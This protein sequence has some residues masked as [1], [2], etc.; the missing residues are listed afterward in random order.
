MVLHLL[1]G[2]EPLFHV[3]AYQLVHPLEFGLYAIL[4]LAG[5]LISVC[6]VKLL[7]WI[8]KQFMRLPA[9]TQWAQPV[10]GGTVVGILGWFVPGALGVGYGYVSQALNGQMALGM[11]AL[12]VILKLI[13]TTTCYSSG[14]AG[15]IFGPSLFIGAMLGG[16]TGGAAH[17]FLPDYTG[18]VGA[19]ALVGMG[20]TFAGIVRTPLTSVIMIF[21]VTRDYSIIVPLM[22]SNLIAYFISSR[23]QAEP[24]YEALQHQDGI[25]LPAGA[26]DREEVLLV[27][28]GMHPPAEQI[29][30]SE[31]V[32][33]V[34]SRVH[35]GQG[36]WPVVD[37]DGL[38]GMLSPSRL[39]EALQQGRGNEP[40]SALL[41]SLEPRRHMKAENFPH[42]HSDHTLDSAM[43]RMAQT[44]LTTLPV[45][46]RADIRKLEAVIS[47]HDIMAA[48]GLEKGTAPDAEAARQQ[49]KPPLSAFGG[50]VAALVIAL[51]LI[52]VL[53][54]VY[55]SGRV[56]RARQ[57]YT[58]GAAEL[59][60][61]RYEEAVEHLRNALSISHGPTERLALAQALLK[62]GRLDE[63][64]LYFHELL[65]Q[66]PNSG[67]AHLGL[68]RIAVAGKDADLAVREYH[69]AIDGS[70]P[71]DA[72]QNRL[73]ARL[74]LIETLGRIGRNKQAQSELLAQF[75]A[76]PSDPAARK[77]IAGLLLRFGLPK[78]AAEVY[79][80][81]LQARPEDAEAQAGL[82]EADLA[83]NDLSG[84]RDAFSQAVRWNPEAE[85]YRRRLQ[86]IDETI[87]LDPAM[88]G[89]PPAERYRRSRKL[90]EAALGAWDQ[91]AATRT[92]P[93]EV[94][95]I[96]DQARKILLDRRPP[97][98]YSEAAESTIALA[99]RLWN[100]RLHLCGAPAA[101]EPLARA[102]GLL[103]R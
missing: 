95:A 17:I 71:T 72:A 36:E 83:L 66:S 62:A 98:S 64:A 12:L 42:V 50:L 77:Q 13:A 1:L 34:A 27:A 15:G 26:R 75:A 45:V 44:S 11:M 37:R 23:L 53:S 3:P 31:T 59:A 24:I 7:L 91:C 35:H 51:V 58:Q 60:Q 40:V 28:R 79:R 93:D 5:G 48:Y 97:K 81:I 54:Y 25:H 85:S 86:F 94:R 80:E 99:E 49:P 65:R 76:M 82:G 102:I 30:A 14:N 92:P 55:R 57:Y 68:A 101:E 87:A 41:P 61:G 89:L 74:E 39:E 18:S 19:Y 69:R 103:P 29:D 16:A 96:A 84:A 21:E 78:E 70:W 2:D 73:Q 67:A 22:I 32:A 100:E 8:R 56:A 52:G 46:S 33:G 47:L 63:A 43:R 38:L 88:R 90:M 4:G 9:R 6:F 10:A 20:T